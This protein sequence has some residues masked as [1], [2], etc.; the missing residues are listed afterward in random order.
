MILFVM[1]T[2]KAKEL[3]LFLVKY[4]PTPCNYSNKSRL[5]RQGESRHHVTLP[6][7]QPTYTARFEIRLAHRS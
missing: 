5:A 7:T 2:E 1:V 4:W 6:S 3:T